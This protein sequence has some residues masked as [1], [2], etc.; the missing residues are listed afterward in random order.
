MSD[1][2]EELVDKYLARH[3]DDPVSAEY[4][5]AK[6]RLGTEETRE[7]IEGTALLPLIVSRAE[8]FLGAIVRAGL[9]LYP[10]ALG[11]PPSIPYDILTKYQRNISSSDIARWQRDRQVTQFLKSSPD[12]WSKPLERWAKINITM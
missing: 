6:I 9:S 4:L 11:E 2:N 12:E 10:Q 5:L 8:E 3:L 7:A 1:A